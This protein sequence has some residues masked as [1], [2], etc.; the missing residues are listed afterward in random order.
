MPFNSLYSVVGFDFCTLVLVKGIGYFWSL[1]TLWNSGCGL[2]DCTD[3]LLPTGNFA[4]KICETFN[5]NSLKML[6]FLISYAI[7]NFPLLPIGMLF[8]CCTQRSTA[9]GSPICTIAVPSLVFRNFIRAT[10][11]KRYFR[12]FLLCC[13]DSFQS[14]FESALLTY[15][16]N[17][18]DWKAYPCLTWCYPTHT[19][20]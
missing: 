8:K 5:L 4:S 18:Q 17:K 1:C 9:T 10:L 2:E 19:P 11:P 12:L 20:S 6:T 3:W 15:R 16:I 7:C 14:G 13:T